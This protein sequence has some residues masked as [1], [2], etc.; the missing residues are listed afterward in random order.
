MAVGGLDGLV[1]ISGWLCYVL[2]CM[3]LLLFGLIV[4]Y[5]DLNT[6]LLSDIHSLVFSFNSKKCGMFTEHENTI[7]YE[8]RFG[9]LMVVD[10]V[11]KRAFR[12]SC[13]ACRLLLHVFLS[14]C[15]VRF[16]LIFTYIANVCDPYLIYAV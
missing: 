2:H 16:C 13:F 10:E 11:R 1:D 14:V 5:Y 9:D 15:H 6:V 8:K 12:L 7:N 3:Q 4:L